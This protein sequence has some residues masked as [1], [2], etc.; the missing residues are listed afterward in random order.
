MLTDTTGLS[1]AGAH[2]FMS[3]KASGAQCPFV[4]RQGVERGFGWVEG[5]SMDSI[6][7]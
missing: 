6:L 2:G 4:T 7:G 1:S 5:I 3:N